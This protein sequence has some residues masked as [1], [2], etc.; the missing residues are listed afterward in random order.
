MKEVLIGSSVT[1][2]SSVYLDH[3]CVTLS[4]SVLMA[5]MKM[6]VVSGFH[7]NPIKHPGGQALHFTI[8][9]LGKRD[10]LFRT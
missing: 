2:K 3:T 7:I 9:G 4:S 1:T 6:L 8:G 5:Q 10:L